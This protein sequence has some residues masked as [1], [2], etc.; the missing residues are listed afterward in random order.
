MGNHLLGE[1]L[2]GKHL[3]GKH[4]LGKHLLGKHLLVGDS[5][6]VRVLPQMRQGDATTC[7]GGKIRDETPLSRDNDT[8]ISFG[9]ISYSKS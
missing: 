3:L 6:H 2:L 7:L 9:R 4:L 8:G 5:L 1:H